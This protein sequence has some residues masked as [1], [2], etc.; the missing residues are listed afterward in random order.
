MG[1]LASVLR[2]VVQR[3]LANRRLLLTVIVGVVLSSALMA[4]VVIY[5]DAIRDLGLK[6]ALAQEDRRDLDLHVFSSSQRARPQEY[7]Q[8]RTGITSKVEGSLGSVLEETIHYGKSATFYLTLPGQPVPADTNKPR[9][10]FQFADRLAEHVTLVDG[11]LPAPAKPAETGSGPEIQV[12]I[13]KAT[14][15][16]FGVKTGD[17][18]DLHPFWRLEALPVVVTVAG[19]VEPN[20]PEER[21]WGRVDRFQDATTTWPTYPFFFDEKTFLTVLAAYLPDI[22]ATYE[23]F[24]LVDTGKIDSRNAKQIEG[25]ISALEADFPRSFDRTS[26]NTGLDKTLAAYQEKLFFTRL[27]LFALMLQVV[28]IVLYYL[29]M[30]STM[31][32]ERQT[33]EIAL[34]KSRG[35]SDTQVMAVYGIEGSILSAVGLVAGPIL[36]AAAIAALGPTPPFRDLSQGDPLEVHLT[37]TAFLFAGFG[38]AMAFAAMLWPAYRA[39]RYSVVHYKTHLARPPQQPAFLRYYLD[40]ALLAVGAF[41]FYELRQRGSLVTDRL[42]GDLSADPLLLATPALFMLMI[43][44]VFLRLFP[45][46]LHVVSWGTRSMAG[47]TI[48]LALWHLVRSP[49]QYSRLILLLLL[50]TAVGM[51]AAGFRATLDRSYADRAAYSAGAEARLQG[52]REPG[53][54]SNDA[55]VQAIAAAT[56]AATTVPAIRAD[57]TYSPTLYSSED[58]VVLGVDRE[59]FEKV[60]YWRDDFASGGLHG[61]LKSLE[62][63]RVEGVVPA[64]IPAGTRYVGVWAKFT[65]PPNSGSLGIRIQDTDGQFWTF[66][67]STSIRDDA[68]QLSSS[69]ARTDGWRFYIADLRRPSG[70]GLAA[71]AAP[72]ANTDKRL[73]SVFVRIAGSPGSTE[74]H[75]LEVD[76]IQVIGGAL[77]V[78][79][80]KDGFKDGTIIEDFETLDRYELVTGVALRA[81]PGSLTRTEGTATAGR[82]TATLQF[83]RM[84]GGVPV[85]GLR[86]HEA[87]GPLPVAANKS[88]LESHDLKEGDELRLYMNA[89]YV[90]IRIVSTFELFPTYDPDKSR[91][92]IVADLRALQFAASRV[93]AVSDALYAN[94]AWLGGLNGATLTRETLRDE[95][96][97]TTEAVFD[98]AVIQAEQTADPLVAASWEGILFLA[99]AAVLVL[100]ALGFIVST[101]LAAQTRSLEFAILRTMGFTRRQIL[102]LVTFEQFFVAVL[103]VAAGTMMGLPLVRLMIGYM[104]LTERGSDVLPPMI[105]QVSWPTVAVSYSL[106]LLVFIGTSASLIL[107]YTRLAV[108]RALRM[109]EL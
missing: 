63:P 47:A 86:L 80:G 87:Q 98:R 27:P 7:A 58:I 33:G 44:L 11:A 95:K 88:W 72:P 53:R 89:Q 92:F 64:I 74:R 68:G 17:V 66:F 48:P 26:L 15:D 38:A 18:F 49:L 97:V 90:S 42:F 93:P 46:V 6:H 41:A 36:A 76:D 69:E 43:A 12:W 56:G 73:D 50:A 13:G 84:R 52:V 105:S 83:L 101:H 78:G 16:R 3:S 99:F 100:T 2:V 108:H 77:P 85:A 81:D 31:V 60:A 8:L 30:V 54:K 51:F 35:A 103:G 23:L 37:T 96:K 59:G 21:Y 67:L 71:G 39:T 40:L 34:L 10:H 1:I 5:S 14:A 91:R 19:I 107:T 28:G 45:V 22:D 75:T 9:A 25:V 57:A 4:S 55:F 24:G 65:L 61:L 106:L 62:Q 20:D 32:V 109:G 102:V 94:E 29:V 104:G 70:F 79:W 82:Y